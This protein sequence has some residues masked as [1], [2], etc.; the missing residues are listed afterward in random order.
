M[1]SEIDELKQQVKELKALNEDTNKQIHKMRRSQRWS[2]I[3][4]IVWWLAVAGVF[5]AAYYYYVQPYV[6]A[7]MET[8]GNAQNFQ[9]QIEDWFAQF[10]QNRPQ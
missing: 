3:L 5:G 8:Y 2:T 9:V 4:T 7:I 10:G 6:Q 1:D